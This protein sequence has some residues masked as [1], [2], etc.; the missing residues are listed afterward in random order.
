MESTPIFGA[1]KA[2][3]EAAGADALEEVL[4]S[5]MTCAAAYDGSTSQTEAARARTQREELEK[6]LEDAAQ[7]LA[8]QKRQ[9]ATLK[10]EVDDLTAR[11]EELTRWLTGVTQDREHVDQKVEQL[12]QCIERQLCVTCLASSDDATG[13]TK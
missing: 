1:V 12:R 7:G 3:V 6:T 5:E 11:A 13:G 10:R 9:N 4:G 2:S 8:Q